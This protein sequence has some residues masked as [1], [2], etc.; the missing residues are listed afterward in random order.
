[1]SPTPGSGR[2]ID[3]ARLRQQVTMEQVL[4][5]LH[6]WDCLKGS[7]AQ[8]R[9][10]CPIHGPS[11]PQGRCFSVHL[12]KKVFQCFDASCGAQGNVLDLWAQS[13]G[14]PLP[15]AAVDLAHRLGITTE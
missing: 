15:Q 4:R 9:G 11:S 12:E 5:E 8:R 7:G 10:P 13:Q 14:L 2:R 1:M 6:W 3:F